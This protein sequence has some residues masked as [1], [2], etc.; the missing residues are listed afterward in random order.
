MD[1]VLVRARFLSFVRIFR[2]LFAIQI[3]RVIFSV[4]RASFRFRSIKLVVE[5][6]SSKLQHKVSYPSFFSSFDKLVIRS[7][8][9]HS[10]SRIVF[11]LSLFFLFFFSTSNRQRMIPKRKR[12]R[13]KGFQASISG[14]ECLWTHFFALRFCENGK[15]KGKARVAI[16][17]AFSSTEI[18]DRRAIDNGSVRPRVRTSQAANTRRDPNSF[19][20]KKEEKGKKINFPD[21]QVF[22][23]S[24]IIL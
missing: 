2:S 10:K 23:I 1:F 16:P 18:Y 3:F 15:G 13:K 20:L 7:D 4:N 6:W 5:N 11:L 9:D 21:F 22:Q 14:T 19:R 17:A 8:R 24:R 12:R